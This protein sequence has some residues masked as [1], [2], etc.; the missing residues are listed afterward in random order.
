MD[1][2]EKEQLRWFGESCARA[3]VRRVDGSL[4]LLPPRRRAGG[5]PSSPGGEWFLL[6]GFIDGLNSLLEKEETP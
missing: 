5:S 2:T 6:R 4:I 3:L 1:E